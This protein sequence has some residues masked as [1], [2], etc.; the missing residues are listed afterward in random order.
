MTL[1][2]GEIQ[3]LVPGRLLFFVLGLMVCVHLSGAASAQN[4]NAEIR[5]ALVVGNTNY[6][7]ERLPNARNDAEG[8]AATLE[9]LD[10][11]VRL[12]LDATHDSF[13]R[14]IE[15]FSEDAESRGANVVLVYYAGHG[16]QLGGKN[17]LIPVDAHIS[18]VDTL[19]SEGVHFDDLL[20]LVGDSN[21]F[22][23]VFL[24]ACQNN[25][26]QD[27]IESFKPGLA[28]PPDVSGFLIGFATQP[29]KVAYE[30]SGKNSP[31]ASAL[32]ANMPVPGREVLSVLA[33]VNQNVRKETGGAQVP[34]VQFS[35]KPEFFFK[36]GTES[37]LDVEAK[38]WKL[39]AQQA[40]PELIQLYLR[41]Y[42]EGRFVAEA[43]TLLDKNGGKSPG[44]L[45][46]ASLEEEIW[47]NAL[48]T[49][50]RSLLE[51][52][53]ERFPDGANLEQAKKLVTQMTS[54]NPDDATPAELCRKFATHPNDATVIY[55]GVSL[56]LLAKNAPAAI[57]ACDQAVQKFPENP[58]YKALLA[59]AYAANGETERAVELYRKAAEAEDTRA[60][61]SLGLLYE[62]GQGVPKNLPL[63]R[64]LFEEAYGHGSTD[65]AI[66][67]AVS[68]Y[69]GEGG[70][71]D[72]PRAI[73]LLE[74]ASGEGAAR[75][76]YNLGVFA[77]EGIFKTPEDAVGF[78][79]LAAEQGYAEGALAAAAIYDE[80]FHTDKS[81]EKASD[82]LLSALTADSGETLAKV[83]A[84]AKDWS[85]DTIIALQSR[86][87]SAGY[88][89]GDL[90]G[91]PG[92][93]FNRGLGLW[94]LYGGSPS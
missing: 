41:R 71:R 25:P 50:N 82:L 14:E 39:S 1:D 60:L 42:P 83:T 69:S 5:M 55:Q 47:S 59:R 6:T 35:V 81:A 20:E 91:V 77:K 67:L 90:D 80:G 78:F 10:F 74:Y 45:T 66:N 23:M 92:P 30:G 53:I 37:D 43:R 38:F 22:K 17:Y 70:K 93:L 64:E 54:D 94:R 13:L 33:K 2:L 19:V 18:D 62:L 34:Y 61:V 36:P 46:V 15:A 89:D 32:L 57:M 65:G 75:A 16:V 21:A 44:N 84:E 4:A 76:T 24:D 88:Y 12:V 48:A 87:Q 58:H 52:Y 40:D 28:P 9:A 3:R 63:A 86:M 7:S 79:E 68:L 26:F 31:Y 11:D 73:G 8:L 29:G 27:R 49:R 72:V 85:R 56:S 51:Y